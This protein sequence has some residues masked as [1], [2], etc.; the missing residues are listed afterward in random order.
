MELQGAIEVVQNLR[1]G[2]DKRL[3]DGLLLLLVAE[4]LRGDPEL[5]DCP[6]LGPLGRPLIE[7]IRAG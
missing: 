6:V 2:L 4:K 5:D 1:A 7:H 3:P